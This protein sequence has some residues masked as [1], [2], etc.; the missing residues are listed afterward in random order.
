MA[1]SHWTLPT[2]LSMTS[3]LLQDKHP[4]PWDG[5]W[6]PSGVWHPQPLPTSLSGLR[7]LLLH[8]APPPPT[9]WLSCVHKPRCSSRLWPKQQAIREASQTLRVGLMPFSYSL[10]H[11]CLLRAYCLPSSVL[12]PGNTTV[13]QSDDST[14]CD[15]ACIL[16]EGKDEA[17]SSETY[18]LAGSDTTMFPS[19]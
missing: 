1:L 5:W 6:G 10:I 7:G 16:V 3:P 17:P 14:C 8:G 11:P 13:I 18:R 19:L 4:N 12:G 9:P 15:G 2:L